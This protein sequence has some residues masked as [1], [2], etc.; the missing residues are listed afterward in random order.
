MGAAD[1]VPGV[2]GGTIALITGI[3]DEL[4]NSIKNIP[5][6]VRNL[7]KNRFDLRLF[8][9]ELNGNFL[10]ALLLGIAI[11]FLSLAKIITYLLEHQPVSVWAFF[12]G[13]I[14]ASTVFIARDVKWNFKTV[15]AFV[16]F[17]AASFLITAPENS[18]LQSAPEYWYIFLCGS[19]AI[20]A[21]ILPGI[22]GSFILVL[23]GQYFFMMK[24]LAGL[25]VVP[26]LIFLTGAVIGIL[27]FS[28]IL[29]WLLEHF[30]NLTLASLMGFMFGS[31][32]K[33]WPWKQT[34][35]TFIDAHGTEQPL[36]QKNLLPLD[37]RETV[38]DPQIVRVILVAIAGFL[39]IFVIE[40]IAKRLNHGSDK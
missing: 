14:L 13:L 38:A 16:I 18:P 20:C 37:Y 2:S 4:I 6:A 29:S 19:I 31:L 36:T 30:K 27:L 26:I 17:A 8:W 10:V 7:F 34:L 1:V 32:N 39:L 11:S 33:I 35:D 25:N 24:A 12:S 3:Y 22:S 21:M 5:S 15:A 40:L 9:K 23:L 28:N